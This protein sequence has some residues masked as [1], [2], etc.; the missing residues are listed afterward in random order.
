MGLDLT[1]KNCAQAMELIKDSM[2]EFMGNLHLQECN[3]IK[4]LARKDKEIAISKSFN[5]DDME[6]ATKI[7]EI[8][9]RLYYICDWIDEYCDLTIETLLREMT[10]NQKALERARKKGYNKKDIIMKVVE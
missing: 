1:N 7:K 4:E 5:P 3:E 9:E 10:K 2:T 6:K 8:G